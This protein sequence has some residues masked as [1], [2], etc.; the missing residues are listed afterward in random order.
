MNKCLNASLGKNKYAFS[1]KEKK[2]IQFFK[3]F[4]FNELL[5]YRWAQSYIWHHQGTSWNVNLGEDK[6]CETAGGRMKTA[7]GDMSKTKR[8]SIIKN[9]LKTLI[10]F[11]AL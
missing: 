8:Q 6:P 4:P 3:Q 7:S 5:L 10:L 2:K 11:T 9:K 1:K